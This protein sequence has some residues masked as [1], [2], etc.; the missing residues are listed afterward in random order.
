MRIEHPSTTVTG[1]FTTTTT[2][3]ERAHQFAAQLGIRVEQDVPLADY[4]R[5]KC[6]VGRN[7][8]R[9]YHLP[10]DQQ[11]AT[12]ITEPEKGE[13]WAAT[14]AEAEE[15]GFRRAWRWKGASAPTTP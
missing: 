11:Y 14:V 12:T 15:L 1:T 4:P 13:R 5:I 3:S 7:G 9:I 8:K 2:L 10:F 6:D